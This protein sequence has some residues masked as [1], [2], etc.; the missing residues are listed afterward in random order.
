M[1]AVS[2]AQPQSVSANGSALRLRWWEIIGGIE[3]PLVAAVGQVSLLKEDIV[4][5]WLSWSY[6]PLGVVALLAATKDWGS[7]VHRGFLCGANLGCVAGS[8]LNAADHLLYSYFFVWPAALVL[9]C[10]PA[11]AAAYVNGH[12]SVQLSRQGSGVRRGALALG[13]LIIFLPPAA[14][15]F[16]E[17]RW[18][19]AID[20][21]LWSHDSNAVAAGL[22]SLNDYPLC[23][24]RFNEYV[25]EWV[26]ID[27]AD[28][29]DD[30]TELVA[31]LTRML[32]PDFW[33]C[34]PI[35]PHG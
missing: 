13:A 33:D 31:Q 5:P 30:N 28:K 2:P 32:G 27:R 34:E 12:R 25:C 21:Q 1:N 10:L 7:P 26:V 15:Q 22:R 19:V 6:A 29:W 4:G 8:L 9:I 24:G 18:L 35:D 17:A 20:R 14:A 16:T 11:F 3:L 23:L